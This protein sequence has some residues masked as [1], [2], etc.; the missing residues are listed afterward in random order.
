MFN[1]GCLLYPVHFTCL[2][3]LSWAISNT[4]VINM[5]NWYEQWSK[6]GATPNFRLKILKYIFKVSIGLK[7]G[8][9]FIF[10]T[11]SVIFYWGFFYNYFLNNHFLFKKKKIKFKQ[12]C[13][14]PIFSDFRLTD[15]MVYNHPS[16]RCGGYVLI[17]IFLFIPSAL[18]LSTFNL[19]TLK[20]KKD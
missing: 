16:L 19:D 5:N 12:K 14:L 8:L 1:S 6:A 4:E 18:V 9:K 10:L 7:I 20:I 11:K 13:L 3:D 2:N 17:S 15:W